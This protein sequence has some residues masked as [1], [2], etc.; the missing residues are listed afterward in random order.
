M[1]RTTGRRSIWEQ[2]PTGESSNR[3]T[4]SPNWG[5]TT[6]VEPP[7]PPMATPVIEQLRVAEKKSRDRS[8]EKANRSMLIRGLPGRLHQAIKEIA[9]ILQVRADDVARA[10]LEYG[11]LC[12]QRGEIHITPVLSDQHLTL[13]PSPRSEWGK[14]QLPGWYE[15]I[16]DPQAPIP[17]APARKG[18]AV[19]E[20][21]WQRQVSYRCIPE[22]VQSAIRELHRQYNVPLGEI[23]TLLLGYGLEAYQNGRLVLRPQPR[24]AAGVQIS[25]R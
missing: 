7:A 17:P 25:H 16:W 1:E 21:P 24:Q 3:P 13:F 15:K 2:S 14:D 20:K 18:K 9:S 8:W 22:E 5:D 11:L 12:Y 4:S 6:E 10:F 23:A 19:A